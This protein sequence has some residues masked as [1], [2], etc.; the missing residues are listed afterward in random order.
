MPFYEICRYTDYNDWPRNK[1]DIF[2]EEQVRCQRM[3][4]FVESLEDGWFLF[5]YEEMVDK[6]F[7]ALN[8]YLGFQI[9]LDTGVPSGTGKEKAVRKKAYGDWRYWFTKEDVEFFKPAYTPYM[10]VVGHDCDD[11]NLNSSPVIEPEFSSDYMQ[12]FHARQRKTPPCGLSIIFHNVC[13][14]KLKT[15]GFYETWPAGKIFLA[16]FFF[17]NSLYWLNNFLAR[18]SDAFIL[19]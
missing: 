5:R 12:A 6:K 7:D 13:L 16:V 10:E 17:A 1:D 15:W 9:G 19:P 14:K 11:W 18:I 8:A 3:R 2:R 4:D